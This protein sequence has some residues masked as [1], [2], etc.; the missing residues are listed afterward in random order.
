MDNKWSHQPCICS[1]KILSTGFSGVEVVTCQK[2]CFWHFAKLVQTVGKWYISLF[3]LKGIGDVRFLNGLAEDNKTRDKVARRPWGPR[4]VLEFAIKSRFVLDSWKTSCCPWI[5]SG[6]LENS[7]IF[8]KIFIG[9]LLIN[10]NIQESR[11]NNVHEQNS[12]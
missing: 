7:W 8:L 12:V 3:L 1:K 9:E 10:L 4:T 11:I 5:F 6:V 2:T